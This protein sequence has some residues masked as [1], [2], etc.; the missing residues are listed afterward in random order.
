MPAAAGPFCR[1]ADLQDLL[2]RQDRIL[3]VVTSEAE[4]LAA[5]FGTPR[6]THIITDGAFALGAGWNAG[7]RMAPLWMSVSRAT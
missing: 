3:Q 6:R 4:E 1:I 5:K 2:Q 7:L